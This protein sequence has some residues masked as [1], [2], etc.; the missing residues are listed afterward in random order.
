[1]GMEHAE[2]AAAAVG[3]RLLEV[4]GRQGDEEITLITDVGALRFFHTQ[5]CCESF[6][7]ADIA[8][9]LASCVGRTIVS[10]EESTNEDDRPSESYESFTWTFYLIT[11]DNAERVTL[12]FLGESNGYYSERVD[13]SWTPA[14]P[15][16]DHAPP[17]P[18]Q[19]HDV[20]I[21]RAETQTRYLMEAVAVGVQKVG[22]SP[23]EVLYAIEMLREAWIHQM[24]MDGAEVAAVGA[25]AEAAR[26]H[27]QGFKKGIN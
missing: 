23:A 12:R 25:L 27:A 26:E 2:C 6:R 3:A 19:R 21:E 4:S 7:L 1:M 17:R 10:I 20:D 16:K 11:F 22:T 24:L 18:G 8:G 14:T 5:D 15:V 9:D 13:L